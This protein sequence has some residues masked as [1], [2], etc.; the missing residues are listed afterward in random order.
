K[1]KKEADIEFYEFKQR[2]NEKKLKAKVSLGGPSYFLLQ[3]NRNSRLFTQTVL[4][5]FRGGTIEATLAS[6]LLNV[7]ANKF[8]KLEAQIYK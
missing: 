5:A 4:D 3:L 6:N 1:L 7:Q 2:E 8:N